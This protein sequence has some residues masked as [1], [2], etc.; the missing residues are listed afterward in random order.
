[1]SDGFPLGS[2]EPESRPDALWFTLPGSGLNG[3]RSICLSIDLHGPRTRDNVCLLSGMVWGLGLVKTSQHEDIRPA[4]PG[5]HSESRQTYTEI[6]GQSPNRRPRFQAPEALVWALPS[7]Y[8]RKGMLVN[9]HVS[10][11]PCTSLQMRAVNHHVRAHQAVV[12]SLGRTM[13]SAGHPNQ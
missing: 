9:M 11:T 3:A 7:R 5:R 10:P 8:V 12:I 6:A 2:H 13:L 1:M 4:C